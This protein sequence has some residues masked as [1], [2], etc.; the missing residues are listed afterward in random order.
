MSDYD[1]I[2]RMRMFKQKYPSI[3][4]QTA[5]SLAFIKD[6]KE[7][8]KVAGFIMYDDSYARKQATVFLMEAVEK[9]PELDEGWARLGWIQLEAR[10]YKQAEEYLLKAI[11]LNADS[12]LGLNG[13][14]TLY[15][16]IGKFDEAKHYR[17]LH[18][19]KLEASELSNFIDFDEDENMKKKY[20]SI[21]QKFVNI[22]INTNDDL[23]TI[24]KIIKL[25]NIDMFPQHIPLILG[26]DSEETKRI[27]KNN[28][29]IILQ[30]LEDTKYEKNSDLELLFL[31]ESDEPGPLFEKFYESLRKKGTSKQEI[32][33]LKKK[34]KEMEIRY[35]PKSSTDQGF[36]VFNEAHNS[37][38]RNQMML[39][40][41]AMQHFWEALQTN[42]NYVRALF[43]MVMC[44]DSFRENK[45]RVV[46]WFARIYVINSEFLHDRRVNT[47][48]EKLESLLKVAEADYKDIY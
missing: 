44:Y 45:A 23:I 47:Q 30:A 42:H 7:L 29:D 5:E 43:G 17:E 19:E 15:D 16:S 39:L 3:D 37:K 21:Y 35:D 2:K 36:R 38:K 31:L 13:L 18:Q 11:D 28:K 48:I 26:L 8:V 9:N 14:V 12:L 20:D 24:E 41:Q 34:R 1:K 22:A 33:S 4:D 25:I 6:P 10:A 32:E 46:E 40:L 27:L